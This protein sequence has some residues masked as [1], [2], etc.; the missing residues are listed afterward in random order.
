[1][2]LNIIKAMYEKPMAHNEFNSYSLKVFP[3]RSQKVKGAYT[4]H[5]YSTQ[6]GSFSQSK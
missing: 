5:S 1:M 2:H 4:D 3:L 6:D